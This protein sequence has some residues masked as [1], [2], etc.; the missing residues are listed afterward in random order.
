MDRKMCHRA[1]TVDEPLRYRCHAGL[2]EA[3]LPIKLGGETIGSM[4][5]GQ[6]RMGSSPPQEIMDCWAKTRRL[7]QSRS[8]ESANG[9][10]LSEAWNELILFDE[11]KIEAMLQL[12]VVLVRFI[13]SQDYV[14]LRRGE[15]E[16]RVI[17]YVEHH[18]DEPLHLAKAAAQLGVSESALSHGLH[19]RIGL[20]F[21]QLV[22]LKKIERFEALVKRDPDLSIRDAAE[23]I[24][25]QDPLYFS[26]L[27]RR[28]REVPPSVFVA[29]IRK[30]ISEVGSLEPKGSSTATR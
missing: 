4:M 12:F 24:G 19:R 13:V 20:S 6:I 30:M 15:L 16:E 27:Y 1:Q 2:I 8:G 9:D 29:S 23:L 25:F 7:A 28:I 10:R 18:L 17:R 26:R 14:T 3:I 11:Q 21:G 22:A 5:V